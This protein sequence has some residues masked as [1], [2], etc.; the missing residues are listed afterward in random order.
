MG[1]IADDLEAEVV[2][3]ARKARHQLRQ[4]MI[5][6]VVGNAEA[7]LAVLVAPREAQHHL[8]VERQHLPGIARDKLARLG[9]LGAGILGEK[10]DVEQFLQLL[11]LQADGRLGA[12]ELFGGARVAAQVDDRQERAKKVG[13]YVSHGGGTASKRKR[14]DRTARSK[15]PADGVRRGGYYAPDRRGSP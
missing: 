7:D 12:A 5:G 6:I 2:A 14:A 3:A 1:E 8:V 11:H 4:E 10:G 15:L 13:R 9:R